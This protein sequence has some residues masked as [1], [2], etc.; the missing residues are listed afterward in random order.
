MYKSQ[1]FLKS[2]IGNCKTELMRVTEELKERS[3]R[4]RILT[5]LIKESEKEL[6]KVCKHRNHSSECKMVS[7]R[8]DYLDW[9]EPRIFYKCLDCGYD[10]S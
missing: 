4:A 8:M 9:D 10:W 6:R 5:E 3:E 2:E 7:R 1:K